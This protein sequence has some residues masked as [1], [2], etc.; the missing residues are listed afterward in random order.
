MFSDFSGPEIS[1]SS[2]KQNNN[3][4]EF[5]NYEEKENI[6]NNI[7]KINTGVNT[8][9]TESKDESTQLTV[10][11]LLQS[12]SIKNYDQ[13]KLTNFLNNAYSLINDVL[14]LRRDEFFLTLEDNDLNNQNFK[15]K[16]LLKFP[17]L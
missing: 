4:D 7:E 12:E 17:I 3:K 10:K 14:L 8:I 2:N 1:F 16:S 6:I 5:N 11:D 13:K 9:K 15:C